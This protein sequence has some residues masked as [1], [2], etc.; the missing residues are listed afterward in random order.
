[1]R[2]ISIRIKLRINCAVV[3]LKFVDSSKKIQ[4][5]FIKWRFKIDCKVVARGYQVSFSL[6]QV[7]LAAWLCFAHFCSTECE[8]DKGWEE[9]LNRIP[10]LYFFIIQMY[11]KGCLGYSMVLVDFC[12]SESGDSCLSCGKCLFIIF[13]NVL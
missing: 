5:Y 13:W 11:E 7:S 9:T 8:L 6:R 1:M 3:L 12:L 4:P 2:S 10:S